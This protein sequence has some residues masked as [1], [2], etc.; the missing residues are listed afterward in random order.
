MKPQ[1]DLLTQPWIPV[2]RNDGTY[3]EM[4]LRE[5]L[6]DAADIR[7]VRDPLPI[8][9]FSL[10]RLLTALVM[11][12]FEIWNTWDLR[13]LLAT[14]RF[15]G[16]RIA[17]YFGDHAD[18]F[19]LFSEEHPFLQTPG[20]HK[21]KDKPFAGLL[22][23]IP[24]GTG[25]AHFHHGH[26]ITFGVSE[27]VAARALTTISP[28]MTAGGAGLSPSINGAPP[29]YVLITGDNLFQTIC[30][31][32]CAVPL[33]GLDKG[34]P[35]AWSNPEP[36]EKRNYTSASL[37]EGLTWRPRRIRLIP[38]P[39]G[40]CS[41]T[42]QD[43]D[44]TVSRMKFAAGASTR[45][46]AWTD[47]NVPYKT[48][49]ERTVLR[50]QEGR[51]VWRDTGPLLLLTDRDYMGKK[52][53]TRFE[54]P[55]VV[56][57]LSELHLPTGTPIGFVVYGMRTDLKMKV[58]EWHRERLDLPIP[59]ILNDWFH[60]TAQ[61]AIETAD[62]AGSYIRKH[63]K[64]AYPRNAKGNKSGF[65]SLVALAGS[66]FW[67]SLRDPYQSFL[68]DLAKMDPDSDD[69]EQVRQWREEVVRTAWRVFDEAVGNLDTDAQTLK[70]QMAARRN[71]AKALAGLAAG[72]GG[73]EQ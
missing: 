70:R 3:T 67:S 50:P 23:I 46:P 24:S 28:F 41:I 18:E 52:Y 13:K 2:V 48:T 21:E 32:C 42:E 63:I 40:R 5:A 62:S 65:D 68:E 20:M 27:A 54:R 69:T 66:D 25:A 34:T 71:F 61:A 35:P 57:Q 7:E 22:P 33:D 53:T 55:R 72:K 19:D 8:V 30:Y 10:Y 58:F 59:L 1:F 36:V 64:Q 39:A 11:D 45:I 26:E 44:V 51:E 16:D 9:E 49:K 31:N 15:D 43:C 73:D 47:P 60:W 56:D 14:S 17:S 12:A 29:W 37:L 38:G 4:G 6:L